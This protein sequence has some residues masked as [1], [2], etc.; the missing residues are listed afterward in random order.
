MFFVYVLY[1]KNFDKIYIGYTSNIEGRMLSHN[2]LATKGFTIKYRP[3]TLIFY[4]TFTTKTEAMKR[5]KALK[6]GQG[7]KYIWEE[8]KRQGLISA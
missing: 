5:E 4:E 3:W 1:S 2:Q 8:I 6:G 7:R